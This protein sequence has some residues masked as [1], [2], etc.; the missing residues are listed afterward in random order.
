MDPNSSREQEQALSWQ[1]AFR[2]VFVLGS[3]KN[4]FQRNGFLIAT[5]IAP[6]LEILWNLNSEFEL[7]THGI[8]GSFKIDSIGIDHKV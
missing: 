1:I 8:D 5:S 3:G 4:G 2:T 7:L 6:V